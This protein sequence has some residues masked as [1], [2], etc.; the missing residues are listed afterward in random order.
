MVGNHAGTAKLRHASQALS[1]SFVQDEQ[2]ATG[3]CEVDDVPHLHPTPPETFLGWRR[4]LALEDTARLLDSAPDSSSQ[5]TKIPK[6]CVFFS[7]KSPPR[8]SDLACDVRPVSI[9]HP[10]EASFTDQSSSQ[11]STLGNIREDSLSS[12]F[13]D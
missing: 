12:V 1:N 8:R 2:T 3:R 9:T 13:P 7:P 11:G 10:I 6:S 4:P 5:P